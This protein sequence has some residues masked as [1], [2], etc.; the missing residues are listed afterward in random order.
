MIAGAI[1]LTMFSASCSKNSSS[2][3]YPQPTSAVTGV[4]LTA[5]TKFG[6][7]L[8]D[9]NG[10]SLYFFTNDAAGSSTCVGGC[11]V[12][13]LPFYKANPAIGTGLN[14]ADFAETARADGSKQT[15]YKGWPLYYFSGDNKAGDTNGDAVGNLWAIAKPD[16]TVMV[17]NAQLVGLDGV[18]YNDQGLPGASVSQYITDANGHTLY[19][20]S[21]DPHATNIFTRPDYSNNN[22]WPIDTVNNT[23]NCP[24]ILDKTQFTTI[25]VVGRKQLVYKGHPLYYFGQDAAQRGNTKGVSAPTPGAAIFKVSNGGTVVI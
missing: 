12:A 25:T 6:N 1:I 9:N 11:A 24:S 13:W 4:Q 7:I 15:T 14:A 2:N 21:P 20:H 3:P 23:A 17:A 5:N 22:V 19:L 8:T 10:S 18:Q 16:Y